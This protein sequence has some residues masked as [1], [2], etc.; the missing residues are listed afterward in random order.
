MFVAGI[1]YLFAR[2]PGSRFS[3][4]SRLFTKKF[5][6]LLFDDIFKQSGKMVSLL[7]LLRAIGS[8]PRVAWLNLNAVIA[9]HNVNHHGVA[10]ILSHEGGLAVAGDRPTFVKMPTGG[11][12][13]WCYEIL[14]K[15]DEVLETSE[16]VYGT[17]FE[18]RTPPTST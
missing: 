11:I 6:F 10:P 8:G 5:D 3:Y 14:G 12:M 4:A 16:P 15:D 13:A 1:L 2:R 7:L 18:A 9:S 17:Q